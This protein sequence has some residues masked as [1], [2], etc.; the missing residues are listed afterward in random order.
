MADCK[1]GEIYPSETSTNPYLNLKITSISDL[2][3]DK[4]LSKKISSFSKFYY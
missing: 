1:S 3:L 2:V 4:A